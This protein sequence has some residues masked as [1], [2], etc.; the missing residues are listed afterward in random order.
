MSAEVKRYHPAL[1]FLHWLLALAILGAIFYGGVILGDVENSDP[2]K[3][4]MLKLHAALGLLILAF[5]IVRLVVRVTTPRPA[6]LVSGKPLADKLAVAIHH[7]LYTLTVLVVAAGMALAFSTNLFRVL[8]A[9]T[10]SLPKDF[11]DYAAHGVH[12]A[13]AYALLAV[14]ALHLAGALQHQFLLKDRIMSRMSFFGK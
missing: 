6:P 14:I 4:G 5:T 7:L 13:L 2:Q 1:V 9:H 8:L 12:A 11:D 3:V 10:G